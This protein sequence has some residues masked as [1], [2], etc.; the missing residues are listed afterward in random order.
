MMQLLILPF[1]Y[2]GILFVFYIVIVGGIAMFVAH[3]LGKDT[4][5]ILAKVQVIGYWVCGIVGTIVAIRTW[6]LSTFP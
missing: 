5:P 4:E 1:V 6:A 2:S 3:L